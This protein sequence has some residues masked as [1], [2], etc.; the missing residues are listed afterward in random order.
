MIKSIG[1]EVIRLSRIRFGRIGLDNLKEGEIREL[2]IHEV[3][4]LVGD[5]K[6]KS[7]DF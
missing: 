4:S 6:S 1:Y 3:K 2:S 7:K 5:A